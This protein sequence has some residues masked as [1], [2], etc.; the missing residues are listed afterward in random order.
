MKAGAAI[1]ASLAAVMLV[2]LIAIG[3]IA[4][5]VLPMSVAAVDCA[6]PVAEVSGAWRP[7]LVSRYVVTSSFGM[8]YHP[9]LHTTKLHTGIDLVSTGSK[10]IVAAS[11]G[12]VKV[13]SYNVA[14]GNQVVLDHGGGVQTRYAHMSTFGNVR[15]GQRIAAGTQLGV[16][17]ATGYVTGPH[18][19]FEV[20][21]NGQPTEPKTFMAAR[22]AP[23]DGRAVPPAATPGTVSA[24]G[25]GTG[26]PL[27][28]AGTPRRASLTNKPLP[29]PASIKTLYV[30]AA[31]KYNLPWVLLAGI[32]M[33]ETGH[34]RN[35]TTSSAG[36]Q[37]LMQFM[38][39][40]WRT[41]GIDGD[42]DGR[43]NIRN[44]ADS[45]YSAAN[46]LTKS[47][48]ANGEAGVRKAL[49]AYNHADWYVNDVLYYAHAYGGGTVQGSAEDCGHGNGPAIPTNLG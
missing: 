3:A 14:Y 37:G 43:A 31:A 39:A 15:V 19:H 21:K 30:Q 23:L 25:D 24:A 20:I 1:V 22:G 29:V 48:V 18:L 17:G 34:G 7:P 5:V 4:G 2:P 41:M 42:G 13:R 45:I 26:F 12:I 11:D 49:F 27:P 35:N 47:G 36:A 38:P 44:D 40:T 32:G 33:E 16:E 10:V 9:V 6:V 46:Y 8:R 28:T